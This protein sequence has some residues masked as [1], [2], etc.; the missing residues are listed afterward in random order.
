MYRNILVAID[1][2]DTSAVALNEAIH[3]A[4]SSDAKLFIVH[5]ADETL[6]GMHGRTFSTTLNLEQAI[7][8]LVDA[9]RELLEKAAQTAQGLDVDTRLLEARQ[10]RVSEMIANEAKQVGADL[11]I[12]GRHG[13]RGLA[14]L[15]LGSVAEQVAKIAEASVLLVR[16]H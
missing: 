6:M 2:S 9:G 8:A 12:V 4:R 16:K 14:T 11:I 7:T 13:K 5:V 15:I 1:D 3:L 10:Q